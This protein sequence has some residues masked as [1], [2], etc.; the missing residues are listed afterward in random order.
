[1]PALTIPKLSPFVERPTRGPTAEPLHSMRMERP[2]AVGI[3]K[4]SDVD[5]PADEGEYVTW[6]KVVTSAR[7]CF[8]WM[9]H[10]SG[11]EIKEVK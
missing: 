4:T 1:V 5:V 7:E 9:D 3:S 10:V 8:R 6:E 11:N 2:V